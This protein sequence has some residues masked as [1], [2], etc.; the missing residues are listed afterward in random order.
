MT[1]ASLAGAEKLHSRVTRE[2]A[3]QVLESEQRRQILMFPREADLSAQLGVSRTI[4]RE[5]MKVLVDKGMVQMKPRAGTRSRPR[6]EWRLLDPDIL[7]WQAEADPSPALLRH[8]CEVR[9]AIEPTAAGFAAVRATADE[10]DEI[11]RSLRLRAALRGRSIEQLIDLDLRFHAAIV[12]AS[13]N[14]LLVELS[15]TIRTPIRTAMACT[16]RFASTVELGLEAHQ[17][18]VECLRRRD[19]IAA[20][21]AAEEAVGLAMLA[22]EKAIRTHVARSRVR[23]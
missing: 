22:V 10:L 12:A 13:H 6:E 8:L 5:S 7:A 11:D 18:L 23:Q 21:K 15:E 2:L 3:R 1:N 16:A 19:P 4:L 9:L 20:R 17:A 14:P